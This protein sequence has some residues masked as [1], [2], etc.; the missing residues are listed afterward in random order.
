MALTWKR[1]IELRAVLLAGIAYLVIGFVTAVLARGSPAAVTGWRLVAW[2]LSA[3][4]FV[5][6]VAVAQRQRD[7]SP[8]V[9]AVEV[10]VAVGL[11]AL[12]LAIVG[13]VRSHWND[14]N[15]MRVALLSVVLW[16]LLTGL[17]AFVVALAG[18]HSIRRLRRSAGDSSSSVA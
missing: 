17:P 4:V 18:G 5:S 8:V 7:R 15:V 9:A 14:P 12:G 16:P 2:V 6:H 10:A 3:L 1:Q 11:G 13:P